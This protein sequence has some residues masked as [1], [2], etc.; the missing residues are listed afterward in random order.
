MSRTG[1]AHVLTAIALVG[2]ATAAETDLATGPNDARA[3]IEV[4]S[5][6]YD[7]GVIRVDDAALHLQA[8][9]RF[10]YVG[11]QLDTWTALGQD[12][13]AKPRKVGGLETTE[14]KARVDGL[15]PINLSAGIPIVQILPHY[16]GILYPNQP[17]SP[18]N[19]DQNYF[20]VDVWATPPFRGFEGLEWGAGLDRNADRTLH[21]LRGFVGARQFIQAAPIDLALHEI[22]TFGN[23]AYWHYMTG[24]EDS[25]LGTVE[26]GAKLTTP[27][28][29]RGW[30]SYLKADVYYW[31]DSDQRSANRNLNIDNG[32]FLI[33]AG[34][35]WQLEQR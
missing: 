13:N 20:G 30:W 26:V 7:Q 1:F 32:G 12:Q 11:V 35:T 2:A 18:I 3:T 21:S 33:A 25:Q 6:H 9:A 17:S 27:L 15:I 22:V 24:I 16:E 10:F 28:P 19:N 5:K 14:V 23:S 31:L 4:S 34:V 29:W 8:S